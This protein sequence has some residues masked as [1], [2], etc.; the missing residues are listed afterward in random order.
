M[1]LSCRR[2]RH[3]REEHGGEILQRPA[4]VRVVGGGEYIVI[5]SEIVP[6][7]FVEAHGVGVLSG[8]VK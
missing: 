6:A 8:F 3:L 7:F 4:P 2:L 1:T 5:Q